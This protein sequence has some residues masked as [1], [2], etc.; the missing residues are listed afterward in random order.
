MF[1]RKLKDYIA[2]WNA[3]VGFIYF[4]I[5]SFAGLIGFDSLQLHGSFQEILDILGKRFS[6]LSTWEIIVIVFFTLMWLAGI[7][8]IVYVRRYLLEYKIKSVTGVLATVLLVIVNVVVMVELFFDIQFNG[9][10][11][12]F[13][14]RDYL[15]SAHWI[16]WTGIGVMGLSVLTSLIGIVMMIKGAVTGVVVETEVDKMEKKRKA[17]EEKQREKERKKE[18][19]KKKNE[20]PVAPVAS[21]EKM[22]EDEMM[23]RS[24][25]KSDE[26]EELAEEIAKN[27]P[28]P[29]LE[30]KD[31]QTKQEA[32]KETNA[33]GVP[34]SVIKE[35][36]VLNSPLAE[37]TSPNISPNFE[38]PEEPEKPEEKPTANITVTNQ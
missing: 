4:L 14:A 33:N 2:V 38:S 35:N 11:F 32:P 16:V 28:N 9:N 19:K 37:Y 7:T 31:E 10:G 20:M 34:N 29:F 1:G 12:N 8:N 25:D 17:K 36:P 23:F 21:R 15:R 27:K 5:G 30:K 18:A 13:V 3:G 26:D 6:A 24:G 22:D